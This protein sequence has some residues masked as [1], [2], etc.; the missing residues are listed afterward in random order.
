MIEKP[1]SNDALKHRAFAATMSQLAA[2][3][4]RM[5]RRR[6]ARAKRKS[7]LLRF[8]IPNQ[9]VKD[10]VSPDPVKIA[11]LAIDRLAGAS[12]RASFTGTE[13]SVVAPDEA[14]ASV[15]RAALVETARTRATDR[16]IR[17]TVN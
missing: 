8:L 13:V 6:G 3:G 14:T 2:A 10:E 1:A 17:I 15:L 16:L 12:L 9:T 11:V 7:T 4:R 5:G